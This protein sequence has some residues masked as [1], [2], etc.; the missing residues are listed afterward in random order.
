M[1]LT[2]SCLFSLTH[3]PS[4]L[5]LKQGGKQMSLWMMGNSRSFLARL[6]LFLT[7]AYFFLFV[8]LSLEWYLQTVRNKKPV[9]TNY[10]K[11]SK[12]NTCSLSPLHQRAFKAASLYL[13]CFIFPSNPQWLCP[14]G[15]LAANTVCKGRSQKGSW[16]S[17]CFLS[18]TTSLN[19]DL[20]RSPSQYKWK[21]RF[22]PLLF[23]L[24]LLQ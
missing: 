23:S 20:S 18:Y 11:W 21:T 17:L 24:V 3:V 4:L 19:L 15:A 7:S 2:P 9:L 14:L 6:F 12:S 8:L 13:S 10:I 5:I 16:G 22:F 1:S